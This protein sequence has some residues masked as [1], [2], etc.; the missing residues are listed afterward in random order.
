MKMDEKE[1]TWQIFE[2]SRAIAR[3]VLPFMGEKGIPATPENYTILYFYFEGSSGLITSL[4]KEQLDSGE[5]WTKEKTRQ[6]YGTIFSPEANLN[7]HKNNEKMAGRLK[8]M[9]ERIITE[10][11]SSAKK[12]DRTGQRLDVSMG[13]LRQMDEAKAVAKRLVTVL[14]D[15]GQVSK[16]S[17]ALGQSLENKS[18]GLG[19]IIIALETVSDLALTD[20]LTQI[21]NRRAWDQRLSEEFGRYKRHKRQC[22]LIFFDLDDFKKINDNCGHLVGDRALQEVALLLR[23]GLRGEDLLAR[24]GGEEFALLLPETD[25]EGTVAVAER[26]RLGVDKTDFTVRDNTVSVTVSGGVAS[27]H[28]EDA[29]GEESFE[30]ADKALYLAKSKGKNQVC[31]EGEV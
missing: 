10:A 28:Q 13:E 29:S 22:G 14:D 8:K 18:K 27:F 11:S 25:L 30:R 2:H 20:Q 12:A 4:V 1:D 21:A 24:Y 15:V 3:T 7:W 9:T 23:V 16:L 17:K 26:L 31:H 5:P 19:D 6:I